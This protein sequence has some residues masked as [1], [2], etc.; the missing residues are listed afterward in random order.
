MLF[1]AA[2]LGVTRAAQLRSHK[3][4]V[5][6]FVASQVFIDVFILIIWETHLHNI[7]LIVIVRV[8][9]VIDNG[10]PLSK[11]LAQCV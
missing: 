6:L 1:T 3:A 2:A 4:T 11:L 5:F 10:H 9:E 7:L 8:Q